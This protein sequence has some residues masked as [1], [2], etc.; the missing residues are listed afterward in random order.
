M[1]RTSE[2]RNIRGMA[3]AHVRRTDEATP[4]PTTHRCR[5]GEMAGRTSRPGGCHRG[6]ATGESTWVQLQE[7][8][9]PTI[10]G[11]GENAMPERHPRI[12]A[13]I[14]AADPTWLRSSVSAYYAHVDRIIVSY[15]EHGKGWTGAAVQ[16]A[17]CL[18]VLRSL[19]VDHK[20]VLAPGDWSGGGKGLHDGDGETL[21]RQAALDLAST[22][23]EWVLQIDGDE[24]LP[25][26][27]ALLSTIEKAHTDEATAGIEWPMR[28]LFRRLRSGRYLEV[29]DA[30]GQVQ[31]EYP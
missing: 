19:D 30:D 22:E 21:Q 14:L 31:V 3:D 13:Y 25:S 10:S 26:F 8:N 4:P 11:T 23:A 17:R 24:I 9:T 12:N 2:D 16:S 15:D 20:I 5:C 28:V 18:D 7:S 1:S 27:D 6:E 29:K